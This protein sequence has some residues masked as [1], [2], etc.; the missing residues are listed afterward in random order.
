MGAPTVKQLRTEV[1]GE[2]IEPED[3]GYDE[4]RAV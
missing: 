2:V 4:A 3:E 1:Q